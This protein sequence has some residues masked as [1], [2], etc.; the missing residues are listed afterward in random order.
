MAEWNLCEHGDELER[1]WGT[2]IGQRF[3]NY[4]K[5]W[6]KHVVPMTGRFSD[7]R[8]LAIRPEVPEELREPAGWPTRERYVLDQQ[9]TPGT[10]PP[11]YSRQTGFQDYQASNSVVPSYRG[12]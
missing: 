11:E 10:K 12:A 3:P 2:L 8:E 6:L 7:Y 5:F 4:E 9:P 1:R